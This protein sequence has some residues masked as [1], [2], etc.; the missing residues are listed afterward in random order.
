MSDK[1]IEYN[2]NDEMCKIIK[3]IPLELINIKCKN[4][5]INGDI[6]TTFI[7]KFIG[8]VILLL[9]I[10]S[11]TFY[12]LFI[13][14]ET[15]ILRSNTTVG[16]IFTICIIL[17]VYYILM[18]YLEEGQKGLDGKKGLPGEKG[19]KGLSG[20]LGLKGHRGK[21][22]YIGDSGNF[23]TTGPSGQTGDKGSQGIRGIRGTRGKE[24]VPGFKGLQGDSGTMGKPGI[25]GEIGPTGEIGDDNTI[26]FGAGEGGSNMFGDTNKSHPVYTYDSD[27]QGT[28]W[29]EFFKYYDVKNEKSNR[30]KCDVSKSI[31]YNN[32]TYN[33]C[34]N[35]CTDELT[36][37]G[38]KKCVGIYGDL[39][40]NNPD[41]ISSSGS[42]YICP[43]RAQTLDYIVDNFKLRH[44]ANR[45]ATDIWSNFVT[46]LHLK[47]VKNDT[48]E[49]DSA[50][51]Y[52]SKFYI[53]NK[54]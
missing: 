43:E 48:E 24:G 23:G 15:R 4:A 42:C 37:D 9:T 31:K 26:L 25:N 53:S 20:K 21:M 5:N 10:L 27:Y 40:P 54:Q 19:Q 46:G 35:L 16:I 50:H 17:S 18:S 30:E 12:Y 8:A 51:A 52:L 14:K 6:N 1:T 45:R 44:S 38:Y 28:I 33:Q 29:R 47:T 34:R 13:K 49:N 2:N 39:D 11:I 3:N 36:E 32:R 41:T 7:I 22:G